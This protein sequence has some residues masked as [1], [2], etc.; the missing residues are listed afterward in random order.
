V[1]GSGDLPISQSIHDPG[2][3]AVSSSFLIVEFAA[4]SIVQRGC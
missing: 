1:P 4:F 2:M 3:I